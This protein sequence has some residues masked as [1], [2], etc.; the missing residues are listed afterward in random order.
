MNLTKDSIRAD[1]RRTRYA[2]TAT[3]VQGHSQVIAD[4]LTKTLPWRHIRTLH[5]Y[6]P[7]PGHNEIDTGLFLRQLQKL[8]IGVQIATWKDYRFGSESVLVDDGK[9]GR[10]IVA[11]KTEFDVIIV[12]VVAFND[13]LHRIGFGGGFYDRFLRTQPKAMKIGLAYDD[14]KNMFAPEPHDVQ[15]DLIITEKASYKR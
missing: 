9:P 12:P 3:D 14:S 8:Y 2:M 15:L 10:Q 1:A 13:D 7:I 6:L 4:H 11:D 5:T